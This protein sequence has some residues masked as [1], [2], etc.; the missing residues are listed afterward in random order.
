MKH[1]G[2]T[3]SET[4]SMV[5]VGSVVMRCSFLRVA[6]AIG[7]GAGCEVQDWGIIPFEALPLLGQDKQ[8]TPQFG[9]GE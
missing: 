3:M 1:Q 5:G 8:A 6:P 2:Q 4:M 7:P 9:E